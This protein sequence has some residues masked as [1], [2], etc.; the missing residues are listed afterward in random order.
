MNTFVRA[1]RLP[2]GTAQTA[3][4]LAR[5][6]QLARRYLATSRPRICADCSHCYLVESGASPAIC[7]QC[8]KKRSEARDG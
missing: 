1:A 3:A 6:L 4:D 5:L 2:A 8:G 7:W